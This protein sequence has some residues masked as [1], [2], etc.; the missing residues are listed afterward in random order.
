MKRI[1]GMAFVVALTA[2]SGVWAGGGSQKQEASGPVH[3]NLS[4]VTSDSSNLAEAYFKEV[5]EREKGAF[6]KIINDNKI[7][8]LVKTKMDHPLKPLWGASYRLSLP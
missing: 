6:Q 3:L 4:G 1:M 5:A 7:F 8:D 2:V